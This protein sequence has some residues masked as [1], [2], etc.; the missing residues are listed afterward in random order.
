MS[1]KLHPNHCISR[2]EY[3]GHRAWW[4]RMLRAGTLHSESFPDGKHGGKHKA[5]V[6]CRAKRDQWEKDMPA[7]STRGGKPVL[8]AGHYRIV[9]EERWIPKADGYQYRVAMLVVRM[10]LGHGEY[11]GTN[12]RLE[13][14][15]EREARLRLLRWVK[16]KQESLKAGG[17]QR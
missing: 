16:I 8:P 3:R 13:P 5:L 10:K 12:C 1:R 6:A 9:K 17:K 2:L 14:W 11:T 15:G 7:R 4:L